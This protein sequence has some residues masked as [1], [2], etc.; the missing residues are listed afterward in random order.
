MKKFL[1]L[2]CVA[3][4]FLA[5]C[6]CTDQKQGETSTT[7]TKKSTNVTDPSGTTTTTAQGSTNVTD[8]SGNEQNADPT[9]ETKSP[10][11]VNPGDNNSDGWTKIY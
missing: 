6:A 1:I 4:L 8:P 10:V 3:A 2:I 11:E 7:G 5:L 9:E